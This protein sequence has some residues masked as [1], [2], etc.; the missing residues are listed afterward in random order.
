MALRKPYE[1]QFW[2]AGVAGKNGATAADVDQ[3]QLAAGIEVEREHTTVKAMAEKIALDHL[4]EDG[5]DFYRYY[6][7]LSIIEQVM[8]QGSADEFIDLVSEQMGIE[9]EV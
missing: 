7:L 5:P 9:P 1:K 3:D 2:H 4:T 8:D 6:T